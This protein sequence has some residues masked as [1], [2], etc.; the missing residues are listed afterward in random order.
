MCGHLQGETVSQQGHTF[1][2][3]LDHSGE[4][5]GAQAAH[6]GGLACGHS[7]SETGLFSLS[8]PSVLPRPTSPQPGGIRRD[9]F[10]SLFIL[11]R[12]SQL[13]MWLCVWCSASLFR[14]SLD[15]AL[16]VSYYLV[17]FVFKE[18]YFFPVVLVVFSR[19]IGPH[20]PSYCY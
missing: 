12:G 9:Y 20:K 4:G 17:T 2:G 10:W 6:L 11:R 19:R 3:S 16:V 15:F 1:L 7:V 8:L 18:I 5:R 14:F 13:T